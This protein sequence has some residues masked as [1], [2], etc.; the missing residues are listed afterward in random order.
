MHMGT[1]SGVEGQVTERKIAGPP[2]FTPA[3]SASTRQ[4]PLLQLPLPQTLQEPDLKESDNPE[5]YDK[6]TD[7][8]QV[9]NGFEVD[10]NVGQNKNVKGNL[11]KNLEFG[12]FIGASSFILNVIKFGYRLPFWDVPPAHYSKNNASAL[13]NFE[14]VES[15]ITELLE[16]E[17]IK[18]VSYRTL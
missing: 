8:L 15:S 2:A 3:L 12:G 5:E 9:L 10:E 6:F 17:R 16:S 14:S 4:P 18:Q 7:V 1:A 13:K 11:K